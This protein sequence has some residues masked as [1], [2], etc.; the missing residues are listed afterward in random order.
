M[1]IIDDKFTNITNDI[2]KVQ[3]K[4]NVYISHVG[5]RATLHLTKE[6]VNNFIDEDANKNTISD[7]SCEI[8]YDQAEEMFYI[9]DHGRGIAFEELVNSCTI[10]QSGTKMTREHGTT[11]GENGKHLCRSFAI[12]NMA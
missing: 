7:G 1:K 2:E 12:V 8:F 6:L 11:G 9:R 4:P 10:L 3:A 5:D